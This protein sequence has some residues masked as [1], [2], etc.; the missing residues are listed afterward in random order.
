[1]ERQASDII[2]GL[3]EHGLNPIVFTKK[4]DPSFHL[5]KRLERV[6]KI[7]SRFTPNKLR[8]LLFSRRVDRLR[9][10]FGLNIVIACNLIA[11]AEIVICG[12]N[13]HG[14]LEAL[15]WKAGY[16]DKQQIKME[17][18]QFAGAECIIVCSH[19][20]RRELTDFYDLDPNKIE[21]MYPAVDRE[22]F[23][24]VARQ[25]REK[26]R[27]EFGFSDRKQV[28]L[29]PSQN[30]LMK[31]LSLVRNFFEKTE[32]P[33]ELV[34]LGKKA[35][36]GRNVRIMG[37]AA[38]IERLYQAADATI[39]ASHYEPFGMVAVESV[40]C[41]TPVV[42][43]ERA[44]CCE[45]LEEPA[46]YRI[47]PDDPEMLAAAVEKILAWDRDSEAGGNLPRCIKYD[48]GKE[49]FVDKLLRLL[50]VEF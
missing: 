48:F 1:M 20:L 31:G 24:P 7:G 2:E 42:F 34:L 38:D 27:K 13:R 12:G 25:E 50:R 45:V 6:V 26:L 4:Y 36:P 49:E 3:L 16:F 17:R 46:L 33:V 23:R 14:Y 15:G 8:N 28:F 29:F 21:V 9:E 11:R 19:L 47:K 44:G 40:A 30:H 32:L 22:K 41:G 5:A 35:R 37:F 43:S 18:R 10:E 39:L